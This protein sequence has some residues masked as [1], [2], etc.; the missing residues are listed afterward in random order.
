MKLSHFHNRKLGTI[1]S[2]YPDF[3]HGIPS[4]Y[5]KPSGFWL[6]DESNGD[7][8]ATWC[9]AED[10]IIGENKTD[11][12]VDTSNVLHLSTGKE[13]EDFTT[14]FW[15]DNG[16]F[17]SGIDWQL[18]GQLYKG[19]VI[20]PYIWAKRMKLN[21]YYGWDC[22]SGCFWD[23]SCLHKIKEGNENEMF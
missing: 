20:T 15:L 11:F 2:V 9:E 3:S 6:S 10:F 17:K 16:R 13:L 18:V 1:R 14:D 8:W 19:I 22:A 4:A 23:T 7:G 21:W 12:E 5:E